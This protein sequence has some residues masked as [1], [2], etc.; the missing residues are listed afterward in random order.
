M[1]DM[2]ALGHDYK[3]NEIYENVCIQNKIKE[4]PPFYVNKM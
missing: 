4:K 1:S 3:G 2:T